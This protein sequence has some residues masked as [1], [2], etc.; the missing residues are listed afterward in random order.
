MG[1][2]VEVRLAGSF[3][4]VRDG[5]PLP[6]RE[7]GSR[8]ARTLLAV[9]ATARPAGVPVDRLVAALW[10]DGPPRNPVENVATLVSR[11]RAALGP[12]TVA[13]VPG[14]YRLGDVAVDLDRAEALVRTAR[15]GE[16]GP[17]LAAARAAVDLLGTG[18]ALPEH[19][20]AEWATPA[21]ASAV[22]LLR[23]ARHLAAEA[24]L[25]LPDPAAA[26]AA[27][28]AAVDADPLDEAGTR[29][30]LRAH[31]L[32]GEPARGLAAYARLRE[33]LA[34]ELGADPAPETAAV[35]AALL[36]GTRPGARTTS[37]PVTSAL[38][39]RAAETGR[40]AGAWSA[41]TAG[42]AG[43]VLVTG[44]AGIGKTRL[45]EE[46]AALAEATGGQVLRARC[47]GTERSLFLQPLADAVRP[48]VTALPPSVLAGLAGADPA[49]LA[50]VVPDVTAV[51]GPAAP[52][53][54]AA[55]VQRRRAY[56]ALAGFLLRLADRAPVLLVLDDLQE[57]G[58][59]TVDFLAHLARQ[60]ARAPLL[61]VATL[62]TGEGD[63]AAARLDGVAEPLPVE[64]LD[65]AAVDRLAADAGRPD[66]GSRIY[67]LTR[68]HTLFVVETLRGLEAGERGV[69]GTLRDA[70]LARVRR[71]GPDVEEAMRAASVL[72]PPFDPDTV[73]G[74]LGIPGAEAARRCERALR[75]GLL[76]V[77]GDAYEF[78]NDLVQEVLRAS[79]P[80]PTR[81]S[82]HRRA[83]DV[84]ADRPEAAA[85]HAAAAGQPVRAARGWLAAG[86]DALRRWAAPDA[87]AFLDRALDTLADAEEAELRARLHLARGRARETRGAFGDAWTD[88]ERA[89]ALARES[90]DR[91]LEM[92]A[93]RQLGG[94]VPI[95]G[96]R[97]IDVCVPPLEAGVR[98]ARELADPVSEADLL[99]R[100]AVVTA[101]Q[102]RLDL[103]VRHGEAAVAAA[104]AAGPQATA[105]A[106]DGLKTAYAQLGDIA[107]LE[108][109]LPEL[110]PLLRRQGDLWRLQ[111]A[112]L[113]SAYPAIARC[114]WD[115]ALGRIAAARE[116]N[117]RSRY[118]T[119]ES[120]FALHAGWVHRLRGDATA[121][122]AAGREAVALAGGGHPWWP[123]AAHAFLGGTLLARG[124]RAAAV[125]ELETAVRFADGRGVP[126]FLLRGLAPL[127]EATGDPAVLDRADALL[128]GITGGPW[129]PGA[130]AYF[131]VARAW[132]AAGDPGRA[133]AV[134]DRLLPAA[135]RL[136]WRSV[137]QKSSVDQKSSESM[138]AARSAPPGSTGR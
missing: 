17:A 3:A 108:R 131:S 12:A 32:A 33:V 80:A 55:D 136:G 104:R 39:G 117:R 113:E 49:A 127:A 119:Y 105:A 73:A 128:A 121:E 64:P 25:A 38:A 44:A 116:L 31:Q 43:F 13:A 107:G 60:S 114:D 101:N 61:V 50:A 137:V 23:A 81:V 129:I 93:L 90:G 24:A 4:V 85:A 14:G 109:V 112:V 11:L 36:R 120:F 92:A 87:E 20:D 126:G 59:A 10:P 22:R 86:E 82:H 84:L 74:V 45:A 37:R 26:V 124:D 71:L 95:G 77:A 133:A 57:A 97:P 15:A 67:R 51:L 130:D 6:D 1:G 70:V 134:F 29:L 138:A 62:R 69:P 91:R 96:G 41:A 54:G 52:P 75:V 78:V 58:L 27:A 99:G 48:V 115:A 56:A 16:P 79:T 19:P 100:L 72:G 18:E 111:W 68:G 125:P 35:H 28:Q 103:A 47:Y 123:S 9:L 53:A 63:E 30:L 98:I 132:H 76:T 7:V 46:A 21:R 122:L 34:D 118:G 106:L 65:P 66:M 110:E 135:E 94:D 40:L 42:T 5:R 89:V 2:G 88:H 8:K 83:A 102:L